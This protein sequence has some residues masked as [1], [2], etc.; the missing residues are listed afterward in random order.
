MLFVQAIYLVY[1]SHY[2]QL[3]RNVGAMFRAKWIE[4]EQLVPGPVWWLGWVRRADM[5][6]VRRYTKEDDELLEEEIL[7]ELG[8][9]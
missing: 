6:A 4:R 1:R 5:V 7:K 9:L 2:K 8:L 3:E